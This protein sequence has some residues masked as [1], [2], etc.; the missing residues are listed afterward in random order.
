[1]PTIAC[2]IRDH[3][4]LPDIDPALIEADLEANYTKT[5]WLP[6]GDTPPDTST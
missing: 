5:M 3:V 4:Q 6:G 2:M 1:M